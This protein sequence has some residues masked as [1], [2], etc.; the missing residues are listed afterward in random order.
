MTPTESIEHAIDAC[1]DCGA[2]L[3]GSSVQRTREVIDLPIT[4]V[5]VVEH[6]IITRTCPACKRRCT[7]TVDL[8]GV[9]LGQQRLTVNVLTLITTLR[10]VGRLPAATIQWLLGTVYQLPLSTGGITAVL[11]QVA[12][13]AAPEVAAIRDRIRTSPV[14][15]ADETGWREDGKNGYVWGLST[16][17]ERYLVRG[18]R[19]RGMLDDALGPYL[20]DWSAPE[21]KPRP[22][23]VMMMAPISSSSPSSSKATCISSTS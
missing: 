6:R 10:E 11:H 12:Q 14:V 7:P 2:T 13:R 8:E 23:P 1:P 16:A 19:G 18:G 15:H 3:A 5:R 21:Q 22:S 17:T 20:P 4:P 9:V